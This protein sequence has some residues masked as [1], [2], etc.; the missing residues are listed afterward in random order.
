ML[1]STRHACK[2]DQHKQAMPE[3]ARGDAAFQPWPLR[4]IV[5]TKLMTKV[6]LLKMERR[7]DEWR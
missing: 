2:R 4:S 1:N 3:K 5:M 6:S 7:D